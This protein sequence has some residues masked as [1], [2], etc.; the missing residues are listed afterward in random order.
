MSRTKE[1]IDESQNKVERGSYEGSE[2]VNDRTPNQLLLRFV[3]FNK[4]APSM[5]LL[6]LHDALRRVPKLP[7]NQPWL[8]TDHPLSIHSSLKAES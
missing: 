8:N 4:T 2:A 3:R 5:A 7:Q 1:A 6:R